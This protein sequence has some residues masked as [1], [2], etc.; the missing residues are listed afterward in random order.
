MKNSYFFSLKLL[1]GNG[2]SRA[3]VVLVIEQK[4]ENSFYK[5]QYCTKKTNSPPH[6]ASF[7]HAV[8]LP[9]RDTVDSNPNIL[10][11]LN[12]NNG[13][14]DYNDFLNTK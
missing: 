6:I 8:I 13:L 11:A 3:R 5:N 14:R 7:P 1:L 4:Y 12:Y 9:G 2:H 10:E